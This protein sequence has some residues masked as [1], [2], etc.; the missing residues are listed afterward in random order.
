[1]RSLD[2]INDVKR[3]LDLNAVS[4]RRWKLFALLLSNYVF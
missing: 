3:H 1:M 4:R 2:N